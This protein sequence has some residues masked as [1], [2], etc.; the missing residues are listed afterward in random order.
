MQTVPYLEVQLIIAISYNLSVLLPTDSFGVKHCGHALALYY[1]AGDE[2]G[3]A[4]TSKSEKCLVSPGTLRESFLD[5]LHYLD[6]MQ[7]HQKVQICAHTEGLK[8][9]LN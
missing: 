7:V 8:A 5:A 4:A 9:C 2:A 3:A 6:E 1:V